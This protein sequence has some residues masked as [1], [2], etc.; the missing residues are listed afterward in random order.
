MVLVQR[1]ICRCTAA[2]AAKWVICRRALS[3]PG[4]KDATP[5][6]GRGGRGTRLPKKS[7]A[8]QRLVNLQQETEDHDDETRQPQQM[9]GTASNVQVVLVNP[10]LDRNVGSVARSMLNF[11]LK[12]LVLVDPQ[13]NHLS[14]VSRKY[15]SAVRV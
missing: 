15:I 6:V 7:D 3:L 10:F 1:Q 11:G 14:Q 13:C 5:A 12:D 2:R 8:F 4:S 9:L